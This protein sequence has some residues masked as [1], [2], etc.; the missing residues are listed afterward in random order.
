MSFAVIGGMLALFIWNRWRY[1]IVALLALLASVACGIVPA[2]HA[3][4]GFSNPLLP[5]IASVLVVSAAVGKSGLVERLWR[6]IA[7]MMQSRDLMV[8]GLA[9]AVTLLSAVM[10]NVGA[11]ALFLPV[12]TQAARRQGRSPS[13]LLMPLAFG[14]LV[15]G[16]MTLIGTSPNIIVAS[17]RAQLLGRPYAMFDFLPVG[18]GVS[19]V[20]VLFLAFGW[21]LIPRGRD[22]PPSPETALRIED[23]VTEAR[24][25][26]RSAYVGRTVAEL[27]DLGEGDLTVS[28]IIRENY[29]RYVPSGHW[30]LFAGDVLVLE[31]DP[32]V[33]ERATE[34]GELELLGNKG[35]DDAALRSADIVTIEA[36]V[37][38]GSPLIGSSLA[39][40]RLRDRYHVHVIAVSRRGRLLRTRLRR[41]KFSLGDVI[42]LQGG[43]EAVA[44]ALREVR[45]L[46]L[47]Q[48]RLGL[49]RRRNL[50]L[51]LAWLLAAVG[52]A[53]SGLAPP[54]LAFLAAAVFL[55]VCRVL[56]LREVY[57]SI[58]WPVLVLLGALIP[59]GEAVHETGAADLVA[60]G[61]VHVATLMP[62]PFVIA[63]V[64]VVTM[65]FTP[66]LHH[67]A[68]VIVMAPMATSLAQRLGLAIDPFLMAVAIGASCDFLTPIGH[69]C[70]TLVMGPGGYRFTDYWH[71]GLPL[72][73]LVVL[74][75]T[76]LIAVFWPF[77]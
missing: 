46:P 74:T 40:L 17:I 35:I 27:E 31:G 33:L 34:R 56:T 16:T 13:E 15:G 71:L 48:R 59:V 50:F 70:N 21:R 29:R 61:V 47:A 11:L 44:N 45:C 76:P 58:D 73:L 39:D 22:A 20:G 53:A 1:D 75:A 64:M 72:S 10:K 69:Q 26:P 41:A 60:A 62:P 6:G 68:A 5:L 14:S 43:A 36:V 12:A 55:V 65:V 18:L 7:P 8:G 28:A 3:F 19:I 25:M 23:Y 63:A 49:G 77:H 2:E 52:A 54:A 38:A 24:V 30:T 51:P 67:A 42:V 66:I 4:A 57:D 32:H 9:G 37:G